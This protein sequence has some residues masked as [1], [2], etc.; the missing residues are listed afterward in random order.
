[1]I[2]GRAKHCELMLRSS[3]ASGEHAIL[4]FEGS[5]WILKDLGSRNGTKVNGQRIRATERRPLS[6][7]DQ[8]VF[9]SE[10]EVWALIEEEPPSEQSLAETNTAGLLFDQISLRFHEDPSRGGV[11]VWMRVASSE[12]AVSQRAAHQLLY[13]LACARLKDRSEGLREAAQGWVKF[14]DLVPSIYPD[15]VTMTVNIYRL[16]KQFESLNIADAER[17]IERRKNSQTL[18][19]GTPNIEI[20]GVK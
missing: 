17:L 12:V 11:R 19:I 20:A 15:I 14:S 13:L 6:L 10:V 7:G 5:R 3:E 1:M 8:I 9:G 16:R 4:Y 2:V 18:R